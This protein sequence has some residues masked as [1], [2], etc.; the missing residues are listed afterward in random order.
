MGLIKLDRENQTLSCQLY[1]QFF[2]S[3]PTLGENTN[4]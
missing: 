2:S 4:V 3:Y 1:Q